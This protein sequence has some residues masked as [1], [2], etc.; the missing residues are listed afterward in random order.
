MSAVAHPSPNRPGKPGRPRIVSRSSG[1]GSPACSPPRPCADSGS[2]VTIIDRAN[3]DRTFSR[4]AVPAALVPRLPRH[5]LRPARPG[6]G[7]QLLREVPAGADIDGVPAYLESFNERN[8]PPYER[9]GF[10]V[11]GELQALGHGPTIWRMW[12]EPQPRT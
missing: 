4:R 2:R 10:H 6:L 3:A 5:P 8:L 12:R 11:I 1:A 9:N 7:T